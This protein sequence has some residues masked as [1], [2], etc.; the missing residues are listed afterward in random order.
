M[1]RV[2]ITGSSD[3][4]GLLAGQQLAAA[5]HD[6]ILHARDP[7]R[8]DAAR[9]ALAS[10]PTVV[11]GDLSTLAA[12]HSV[13]EQVN[14]IGRFDAVIHNVGT[15]YNDR[16]RE[17]TDDG[18]SRIFAV[19]VLA[20]YVLT[21]G[22]TRPDRLVYLSS[23]MHTGGNADLDDAQWERR[24]WNASQ[25]YSDTK[26]HDT[27]LMM[28]VSERWTDVMVNAVDPGWVPT[29]M[30]GASAPDDLD[31][32]ADTQAWLA[33]SN[34]PTARVTGSISIIASAGPWRGSRM[35]RPCSSACSITSKSFPACSWTELAPLLEP[36]NATHDRNYPED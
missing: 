28:A 24:R 22:M 15:G 9:S 36:R 1:A 4:L 19:N 21:A 32:G 14:A 8:A 2:F 16:R 26:L 30:D 35:I 11:T 33:V 23:G 3:G 17:G 13:V 6:V 34:D 29:R 25:A 7:Q 31:K 10:S 27:I 20:P 12:M 5:G 18:L